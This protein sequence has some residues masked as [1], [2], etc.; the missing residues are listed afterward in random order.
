MSDMTYGNYEKPLIWATNHI[1]SP[2]FSL[3][4]RI[5]AG[6]LLRRLQRD[7]RLSLPHSRPMPSIA[8]HVHELRIPD[9]DATW[10]IIYALHPLGIVILDILNKKTQQTPLHTVRLCRQRLHQFL[11]AIR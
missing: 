10:R 9:A 8:A 1:K 6:A 2:P 11:E 7:E 3:D 4:A 5:E